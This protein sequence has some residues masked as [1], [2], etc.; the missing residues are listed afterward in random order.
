MQKRNKIILGVIGVLLVVFVLANQMNKGGK[1]AEPV[2]GSQSY[3]TPTTSD[4]I[5]Y[6]SDVVGTHI[7]TSTVGVP[8]AANSATTTYVS[9]IGGNKSVANYTIFMVSVA[10]TTLNSLNLAIQGS[11]DYGCDTVDTSTAGAILQSNINWFS[12][13]DHMKGKVSATS[14]TN[15]SSTA[16]LSWTNAV[17]GLGQEIVLDGLNYECLRLS[18]WGVSTTPYIGLRT[19]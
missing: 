5:T 7:G 1:L 17:A 13:G 2:L 14:F 15:V 18:V 16:I 3:G 11:N 4:F 10:S 9:R 6:S 12:A 8:V 19:K